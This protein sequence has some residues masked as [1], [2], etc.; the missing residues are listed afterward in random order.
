MFGHSI[1]E[2]QT[3]EGMRAKERS[4]GAVHKSDGQIGR[5]N[6]GDQSQQNQKYFGDAVFPGMKER[7]RQDRGGQYKDSSEV[8]GQSRPNIEA[9]KLFPPRRAI[10]QLLLEFHAPLRYEII[11]RI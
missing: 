1:D 8:A 3:R 7:Q 10:P 9:K 4:H 5:G 11:A 2:F 6:R